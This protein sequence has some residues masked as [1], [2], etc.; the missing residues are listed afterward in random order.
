MYLKFMNVFVI[1]L[2]NRKERFFNTLEHLK[3][4]DLSN[5][6]IRK[7][8]CTIDKAKELFPKFINQKAY[9]NIKDLKSTCIMPTWGAVACA[10]SHYEIYQYIIE[11]KIKSAIIVEDDF[12]IEDLMKFNMFL[13]EGLNIMK[14]NNDNLKLIF[15]NYN[16]IKK[17]TKFIYNYRYWGNV[18]YSNLN[19]TDSK[20]NVSEKEILDCPFINTQFYMI[21]YNMAIQLTSKLLPF[22]Y[23]IDIQI[24]NVLSDIRMHCKNIW[25]NLSNIIFYNFKNSGNKSSTKFESDVQYYFPCYD[26]LKNIKNLNNDVINNILSFCIQKKDIENEYLYV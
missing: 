10:I 16:G 19:Y 11:H 3:K 23:Q 17:D 9:E 4:C 14:H 25:D 15:L 2:H 12:E 13:N 20:N 1:N 8:A 7:E 5:Y 24:G 18:L 21:N 26:D 22:T 6:V